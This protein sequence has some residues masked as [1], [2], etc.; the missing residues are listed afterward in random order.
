MNKHHW[1][2]KIKQ[3]LK[4][5]GKSALRYFILKKLSRYAHKSYLHRRAYQL[6][7]QFLNKVLK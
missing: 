3:G 2:S 6:L 4:N 7:S 1:Q 5:E